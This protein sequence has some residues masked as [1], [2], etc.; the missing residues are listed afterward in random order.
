VEDLVGFL[1]HGYRHAS[2]HIDT[3]GLQSDSRVGD[4]L[5]L[6]GWVTPC[7]GDD[8]AELW[9]FFRYND[10]ALDILSYRADAC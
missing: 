10:N 4:Q 5:R 7:P 9:I 1:H 3:F 2:R 8:L 6:E